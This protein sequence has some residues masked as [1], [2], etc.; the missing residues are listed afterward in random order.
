MKIVVLSKKADVQF[1]RSASMKSKIC[2]RPAIALKVIK[3][4]TTSYLGVLS[5]SLNIVVLWD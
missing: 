5:D 3:E 2:S 1:K 4:F